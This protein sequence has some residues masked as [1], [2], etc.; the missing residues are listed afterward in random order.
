MRPARR[1]GGAKSLGGFKVD[2]QLELGA[3]LEGEVNRLRALENSSG[4]GPYLLIQDPDPSR[5]TSRGPAWCEQQLAFAGMVRVQNA[6]PL[7][8]LA[9]PP[10]L[11]AIV[12]AGNGSPAAIAHLLSW[13][14]STRTLPPALPQLIPCNTCKCS[15]CGANA[16][17]LARRPCGPE[18]A[19]VLRI[20]L[21][22]MTERALADVIVPL[23]KHLPVAPA[24]PVNFILAPLLTRF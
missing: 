9:T 15:I 2:R 16:A 18:P 7:I 11:S 13:K 17:L 1:H 6:N 12:R 3:L 23:K 22:P 5:R 4:V 8:Q 19:K 24:L 21:T 14:S 10:G 20:R